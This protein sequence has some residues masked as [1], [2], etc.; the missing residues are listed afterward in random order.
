MAVCNRPN[1]DRLY[2]CQTCRS[3]ITWNTLPPLSTTNDLQLD[4]VPDLMHLTELTQRSSLSVCRS[5]WTAGDTRGCR[6]HT[7]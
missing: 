6:E 3:H 5:W 4:D 7:V 1:D 2:V